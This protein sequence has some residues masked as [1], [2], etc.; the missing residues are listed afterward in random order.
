MSS[1]P[2][3]RDVQDRGYTA[4]QMQRPTGGVKM[5][6]NKKTKNRTLS[7]CEKRIVFRHRIPLSEILIQSVFRV[8]FRKLPTPTLPFKQAF[9]PE[10]LF[11]ASKQ[12]PTR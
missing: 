9:H 8:L 12:Y 11:T 2:K 10:L 3:R 6:T 5:K 1:L 4:G 7:P